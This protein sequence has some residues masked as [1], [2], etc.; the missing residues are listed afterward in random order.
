MCFSLHHSYGS[1]AI[2][3]TIARFAGFSSDTHAA[4]F[5]QPLIARTGP[6][7]SVICWQSGRKRTEQS[8]SPAAVKSLPDRAMAQLLQ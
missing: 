7:A 5:P 4:S 8:V 1:G 6:N 3:V 2:A